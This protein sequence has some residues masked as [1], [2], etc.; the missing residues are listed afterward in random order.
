MS[1]GAISALDSGGRGQTWSVCGRYV[2]RGENTYLATDLVNNRRVKVAEDDARRWDL[3]PQYG[4]ELHRHES[5]VDGVLK[6]VVAW[7]LNDGS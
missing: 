4:V 2:R 6:F 3:S 5:S 7:E 1:T